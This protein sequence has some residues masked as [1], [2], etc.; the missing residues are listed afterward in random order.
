[1]YFVEVYRGEKLVG[2]VRNDGTLAGLHQWSQDCKHP[3]ERAAEK[4]KIEHVCAYARTNVGHFPFSYLVS[5][6]L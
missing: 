4:A 5:P 2:F 1:M 6:C 3:G